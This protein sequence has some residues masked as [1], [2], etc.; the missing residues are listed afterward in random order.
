MHAARELAIPIPH[1]KIAEFCRQWGIRKLSFFGS[2][3]RDDLDPE[4]SDVDVLVEVD[5]SRKDRFRS[6]DAEDELSAAVFA[7]KAKRQNGLSGALRRSKPQ[8]SRR[9]RTCREAKQRTQRLVA[10]HPARTTFG[11]TSTG[12]PS[13]STLTTSPITTS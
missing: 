12:P 3:T 4:R 10:A 11:F 7:Q 9:Q 6:W 2:V 13:R 5:P 8:R 1:A